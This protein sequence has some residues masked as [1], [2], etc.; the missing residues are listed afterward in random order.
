MHE[1][2]KLSIVITHV[3]ADMVVWHIVSKSYFLKHLSFVK[4]W[5]LQ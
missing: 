2:A 4:I 3:M 5:Q 1:E